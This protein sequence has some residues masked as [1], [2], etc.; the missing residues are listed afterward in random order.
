MEL[1]EKEVPPIPIQHTPSVA[2]RYKFSHTPSATPASKST[3][4]HRWPGALQ[5][6]GPPSSVTLHDIAAWLLPYLDQSS[7]ATLAILNQT[8]SL[9]PTAYPIYLYR[10]WS[11]LRRRRWGFGIPSSSRSATSDLPTVEMG[12]HLAWTYILP[13]DRCNVIIAYPVMAEY[14]Q[15]RLYAAVTSVSVLRSLRP[16]PGK[17]THLN[18]KQAHLYGAALMR[19]N[20]VYGDFVRWLSG[21]YTNRHRDWEKVF[22]QFDD[23]AAREAPEYLP[24][25]DFQRGFRCNTEGVPLE[26]NYVSPRAQIPHRDHYDNHP[27]ITENAE[28]VEAK[29]AAE[30]EKTF[31]IHLPRFLIWFIYGLFLAPLQWAVRKG[32]GRICVDCT[33]SGADEIGSINTYIGKPG[34]A[35][36]DECPPVYYGDAFMRFLIVVWRMRL[37]APLRDI[38]LHCDDIDAAFRRIL[39]HPDLAIAFAYVFLDYLIV[40]VGQVFGSRSAPSFFSLTSDIRAFVASTHDIPAEPLTPLAANADLDPLPDVWNP[41][42]D[43]TQA[44]VDPLYVPL[45]AN[46]Q[47]CFL[48]SMFVDDNGIAAYREDMPRALHQSVVAAYELYGF[49]EEDRRQSCL[50]ADKWENFVSHI[51]RYLGFLIDTRR[52]SVTWPLDKREDLRLDIEE[53]LRT[54]RRVPPRLLAKILG[55]LSSAAL[56]A[57]WGIYITAS[58]RLA[59]TRAARRAATHSRA[60]WQ[61]GVLRLFAAVIKDLEIVLVALSEPE[62][63]PT[64][65]RLIAL[66]IPRTPTHEI[67]SDASYGGMGGWSPQFQI[68]WRILRP[69]LIEYGFS[70]KTINSANE[71]SDLYNP[72]GVHINL[73]E[74]VGVFIDLF[75]SIKLLLRLDTPPSGFIMELIADNTSALAW[76]KYA[77]TTENQSVRALAR[78]ASCFI[79]YAT[80]HLISIQGTHISGP[81]NIEADCLSRLLPNGAVPSWDYVLKSCPRLITCQACLLPSRLILT[82]AQLTTSPQIE[83]PFEQLAQE[84]LS[85]DVEILPTTSLTEGW[86]STISA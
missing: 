36:A 78:L 28:A 38:L 44:N 77:A 18:P 68:L 53:A 76:L 75:I 12:L 34:I 56:I 61:R 17:P 42:Q 6:Q 15:L 50:N 30:E 22:N 80:N 25:A 41:S 54:R 48:N 58:I 40:P 74:F 79:M 63:S 64:W 55:K 33:K 1:E 3:A 43:L 21:E 35:S 4:D 2:H 23:R 47:A 66:M 71:P 31:H 8:F 29:F 62:W 9:G 26:G 65:T 5:H 39:Y 27:A 16:P 10:P 59:L 14:V 67:L 57:P 32:K 86:T 11:P 20:F 70:M 52:L 46:E 19:F 82:L 37:T 84:L 51:M 7:T 24:P 81:E 69:D 85:L 73:L 72:D 45:S 60:F 49:P 83:V 13:V